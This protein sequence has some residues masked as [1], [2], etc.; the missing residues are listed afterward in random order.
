MK[1]C[2]FGVLLLCISLTY[3]YHWRSPKILS[4]GNE[5]K[6]SFFLLCISL[7]YSYL[8]IDYFVT[9]A[10]KYCRV[11]LLWAV[12]LPLT[13][14]AQER[15]RLALPRQ[16]QLSSQRVLQVMQDSEGFLWYA[17]EGGGLCR[18]DG[19]Q[20]LVFR[21][22]AEHPDLLGSN[23]VSCVAEALPAPSPTAKDPL[24]QRG[25]HMIIGTFHG[26]FVLDKHDYSIRR[27][28][29]VDDKRVDD[30]IV[31]ANG[32]WWL[33]ANKKVYEYSG[34]GNLLKTY[35]AGD[36][37]LARLHEDRQGRLWAS[38]WEGGLLKLEGGQF[39]PAS[40]PLDAP[41]TAIDDNP[42][43]DGLLIGTIGRGVVRYQP[44]SG[45]LELTDPQDSVCMSRVTLD[46]QGRMLVADGLGNCYVLCSDEQP[47]WFNGRILSRS[48]ADSLRAARHLSA[49]PTA[50]A[51]S[52]GDDLW[53][54]TGRDIRRLVQGREEVVLP[55]TKDVSAMAFTP[56]GT[57]WLATIFG[58]LM[59]YKHGQL[60]T[61]DYAS[62]EHGDAVL[63]LQADSAGRLLIVSDRYVRLYDPARQ[64][65]RQQNIEEE[66]VYRIELQETAPASRWSQ[67]R[68]EVLERMPQWVWWMLAVLLVVLV[69][70]VVYVR[71]LH[72]QRKRFLAAMKKD[73]PASERPAEESPVLHDE[74]LQKAIE[75][76]EQHIADDDYSV[77]QLASDLCMSRMTFYRKIQSATGQKPTEFI[78]TIRLR[79]ATDLL[80]QGHMTVTEVSYATGF[81]SVSYFSRCFRTMFGVPPTQFGKTTTADDLSPS[82]M[83]NAD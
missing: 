45:S 7:T 29:E 33:T 51:F 1:I 20:M 57:L 40:W 32:H 82:E 15:H 83:P 23:D 35:P 58:T 30:I 21:S 42:S 8:C 11:L 12:L 61:D 14:W 69:A 3:S 56:D 66:G 60:S 79:R 5:I 36:K 78:R 72:Q 75:A 2:N 19:R 24:R 81:S 22:D 9:T 59:S 55:T 52:G 41:P 39:V 31:T 4:L 38:Q 70:L 76:V 49:R 44:D 25:R 47:S 67:P 27:L 53:F 34:D 68:E 43:A 64:T 74:W 37:Y 80:Q 73:A 28:A 48:V 16:E 63:A 71:F 54:S 26:A 50:L 77:E 46:L 18:D 65:L 13:C 6:K 10:M 62:N 17:T